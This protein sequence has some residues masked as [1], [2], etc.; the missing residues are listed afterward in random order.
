M[1]N[2]S[3]TGL[4]HK[5]TF[6]NKYKQI[7][8]KNLPIDAEEYLLTQ[9]VE[10]CAKQEIESYNYSFFVEDVGIYQAYVGVPFTAKIVAKG[11]NLEYID[12][13]D[14]FEIDPKTGV[15]S[16]T[17]TE[18]QEGEHTALISVKDQFGNEDLKDMTINISK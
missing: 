13:T 11:L 4:L 7:S 2:N 10:D 18:S 15:I 14:L 12:Y 6:A 8:C 17:P 5:F 16:F 3:K 1:Y 9:I